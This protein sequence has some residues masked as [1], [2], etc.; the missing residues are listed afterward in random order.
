VGAGFAIAKKNGSFTDLIERPVGAPPAMTFTWAQEVPF[1]TTSFGN[2]SAVSTTTTLPLPASLDITSAGVSSNTVL[3]R[4]KSTFPV[5]TSQLDIFL[6]PACTALIDRV[7]STYTPATAQ[8]AINVTVPAT[9]GTTVFIK[10][11]LYSVRLSASVAS[12]GAALSACLSLR[13][14][15]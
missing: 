12:R 5:T 6:G 11:D 4:W 7:T 14:S 10:G 3:V 9:P 2:G 1:L 8:S 13:P 15:Q